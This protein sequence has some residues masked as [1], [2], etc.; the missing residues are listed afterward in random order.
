MPPHLTALPPANLEP[1]A[2]LFIQLLSLSAS[3]SK[4][5]AS[6]QAQKKGGRGPEAAEGRAGG[7]TVYSESFSRA[8]LLLQTEVDSKAN[9]EKLIGSHRASPLNPTFSIPI[10]TEEQNLPH[11]LTEAI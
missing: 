1:C 10:V 3:F 11:R 5:V 7:T 6:R 9:W 8:R 4:E 2:S